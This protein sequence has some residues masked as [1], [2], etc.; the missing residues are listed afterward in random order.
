[1]IDYTS[2]KTTILFLIGLSFLLVLMGLS[3]SV[4]KA[5]GSEEAGLGYSLGSVL[6]RW[7]LISSGLVSPG[8]DSIKDPLASSLDSLED[9]LDSGDFS[10]DLVE[11]VKPL[12]A[13]LEAAGEKSLW[14]S[15]LGY[16]GFSDEET[17]VNL[18]GAKKGSVN[19]EARLQSYSYLE[20][21]G[22]DDRAVV[23]LSAKSLSVPLDVFTV[24]LWINPDPQSSGTV[25]RGSNWSLELGEGGL[26]VEL[27]SGSVPGG[28][29]VP[30]RW[31]HVA[32]VVDSSSAI[33]YR[34]GLQ[35]EE[36]ELSESVKVGSELELG[37]GFRG[38]LDELRVRP[39]RVSPEEINFDR[40]LDYLLGFP[41]ISLV[42]QK[43]DDSKAWEFYAGLLV[44][45]LKVKGESGLAEVKSEDL[46]NVSDFLLGEGESL[47]SPPDY[48]P[49]T[50]FKDLN[51]LGRLGEKEELS[52][53]DREE[54]GKKLD[55]LASYLDLP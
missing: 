12:K 32:L 14:E 13:K 11:R 15:Q 2:R 41:V 53:N 10:A 16:W 20:F 55:A 24:E 27:P 49:E 54:V 19:K 39:K 47:I 43:F 50:V 42:N 35:V 28:E 33:L 34:N 51:D 25:V 31:F 48:L 7:N 44:S 22:D 40:P 30:E 23:D 18:S 9:E 38:K 3:G 29:V 45:S 1:M 21:S 8:S 4:R 37:D 52:Q 17:S 46:K 6:L 36:E 5:R 26:L